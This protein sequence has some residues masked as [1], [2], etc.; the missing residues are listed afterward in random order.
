LGDEI[1]GGKIN[2]EAANSS[3]LDDYMRV[4]ASASYYFNL[5]KKLQVNTSV[6]VWNVLNTENV[7]NKYY[8]V[9][10]SNTVD[11]VIQY[12]LGLTP[13]MSIRVSF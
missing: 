2:Y 1:V 9:S 12:S 7:I 3:R 11:E 4:D 8:R 6:S 13:N 10:D 5:G